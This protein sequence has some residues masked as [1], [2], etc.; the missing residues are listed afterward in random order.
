VAWTDG[1]A[2]SADERDVPNGRGGPDQL[3][4]ASTT[5]DRPRPWSREDLQQRLERLP[6]GHPSSPYGADGTRKPPPPNLRALELPAPPDDTP[7]PRA[8]LTDAEHTEHVAQVRDLLTEAHE[9]G[10]ATELRFFS[11]EEDS[12]ATERQVLHR[13]LVDDMYA[14]A[15]NV[16][17]EQR[18]VMAGG[19]AGAGKTTVLEEHA[20]IDRS[21]YLTINPDDVKK[22]MAARG[23]IPEVDGLSPMEASD[24][25]H[26]ESSH[27]AK[28]L[29]ERA[30]RDGK[31]II[32]DITMASK[33][34]TA[35]RLDDLDGAGY[36][37][38]GIF[39]DIS[40][41]V[42][43]RRA[44][45]RHRH[46]HEQYRNSH[47]VGGRLVP[48]EVITS[49]ADA[50]WGSANRRTFEGIKNKFADWVVYDNS[51]DGRSPVMVASGKQTKGREN[52]W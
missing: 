35:R 45:G 42:S 48:D 11:R 19:L 32:W 23:L 44:D 2:R 39:V 10:L 51:V 47:G 18:A 25:V 27:V 13:D 34:S 9:N 1:Q 12:W 29:A 6:W 36:A 38:S 14:T 22:E 50:E 3:L 52:E 16:P 4:A 37:T 28:L 46:G 5:A 7:E 24:L 8:P 33:Q 17:C 21:Q 30:L 20:G 40:V 49:K 26:E 43:M 31:N 15:A 41:E